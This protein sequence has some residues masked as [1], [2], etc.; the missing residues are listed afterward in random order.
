MRLAVL[1]GDA[2]PAGWE[3][4]RWRHICVGTAP[5]RLAGLGEERR[6]Q[7]RYVTAWQAGELVGVLP[8]CRPGVAA[9]WDRDYDA[10]RLLGSD[11]P[12]DARRW[13]FLG[14]CRDLAAGSLVH[15]HLEPA[16]ADSVRSALVATAVAT[17]HDEGLR[18]IAAY[19]RDAEL[20]AF[21]AVAPGPAATVR[22]GERAVLRLPRV[23]APEPGLA[24]YLAMFDRRRRN[25]IRRDWRDF[26]LAGL[27]TSQL[28]VPD[29][30]DPAAGLVAA[31]KRRHGIPDHPRIAALRLR[32]WY[33]LGLGRYRA[34]AVHDRA[35]RLLATCF[36]CAIGSALDVHEIG[37]AD[38]G[39]VRLSAYLEAGFYAPIRYAL[40][41]GC[42]RV[43]LGGGTTVA[44]RLRGAE[45]EP[46]WAVA[47]DD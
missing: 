19:L 11:V 32:R 26:G 6:W 34:F 39:D 28:A 20:E 1:A 9:M 43:E 12:A 2:M 29:A 10:G 41:L 47:F 25:K 21:T 14:G 36:A 44:K 18:V 16:G 46:V 33:D 5:K 22:C 35:G 30:I 8:V 13:L 15:A 37:L 7:V 31:V 24:P 42:T 45:I 17:G 23:A 40:A 4:R 27:R 3:R 38:N